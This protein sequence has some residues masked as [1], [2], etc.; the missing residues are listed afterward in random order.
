M[1]DNRTALIH[2]YF[3]LLESIY[4]YI[5]IENVKPPK[6]M[7]EQSNFIERFIGK[8]YEPAKIG[9]FHELKKI[10][11]NIRETRIKKIIKDYPREYLDDILYNIMINSADP[12][13]IIK[14][15]DTD[16]DKNAISI[17]LDD[18][19]DDQINS[20]LTEL[21]KEYDSLENENINLSMNF[22]K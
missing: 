20:M 10:R 8:F 22:S 16:D 18:L 19:T 4:R 21:L 6:N 2:D 3:L 15:Y 1:A 14:I 7:I 11:D 12:T 17:V 13:K 5:D 9:R